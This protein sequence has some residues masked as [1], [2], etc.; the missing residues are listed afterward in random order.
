MS[1]PENIHKHSSLP[2][3]KGAI[4]IACY[5]RDDHIIL[6][7]GKE[8]LTWLAMHPD[9]ARQ[10]AAVLIKRAD[11]LEKMNYSGDRHNA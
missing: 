10:V 1:V 3:D 11:E 2:G 8:D 7:F 5:I 4:K 6:D 9:H